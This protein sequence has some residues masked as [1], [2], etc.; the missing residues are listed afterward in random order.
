MTIFTQHGKK[1]RKY[2]TVRS[3]KRSH[4]STP[5]PA[6]RR[7]KYYWKVEIASSKAF[8]KTQSGRFYTYSS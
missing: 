3:N 7:G 6:P 2:K 5:L 4:F 1:W 8:A